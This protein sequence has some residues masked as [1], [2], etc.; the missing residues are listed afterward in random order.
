MDVQHAIAA[1]WPDIVMHVPADAAFAPL[2][3]RQTMTGTFDDWMRWTIS[4][5]DVERPPGVS[6]RMTT[7]FA[8]VRSASSMARSMYRSMTGLTSELAL[9]RWTALRSWM[10]GAQ[11][12]A[13]AASRRRL[14]KQSRT[15]CGVRGSRRRPGRRF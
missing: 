6:S 5:V 7:A 4:V 2:G 3:E 10:L 11:A 14:A 8:S 15:Q 9:R 1:T 12:A 13:T